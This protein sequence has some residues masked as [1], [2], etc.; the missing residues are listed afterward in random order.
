MRVSDLSM[1]FLPDEK[2]SADCRVNDTKL[3]KHSTHIAGSALLRVLTHSVR[4][5]HASITLSGRGN[6]AR[7]T[8][9]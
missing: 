7:L 2:K 4:L 8:A 1:F 5:F 3:F 6:A 9:T